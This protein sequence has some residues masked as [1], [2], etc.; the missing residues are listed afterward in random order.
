MD[1][2]VSSVSFS[3]RLPDNTRTTVT[4]SAEAKAYDESRD[5]IIIV[6]QTLLLPLDETLDATTTTLIQSLIGKW[7]QIPSE[8]KSGMTLPLKY[9]TLTGHIRYFYAEDPRTIVKPPKP[10]KGFQASAG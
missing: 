4:F 7:V 6:L 8:A 9:E 2:Q 3:W 10:T 5:R 1:N